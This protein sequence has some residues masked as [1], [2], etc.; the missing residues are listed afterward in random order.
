MTPYHTSLTFATLYGGAIEPRLRVH[1][2]L[3]LII[4]GGDLLHGS[5][6][7]GV[8]GAP[9]AGMHHV[10]E[11]TKKGIDRIKEEVCAVF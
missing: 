8:G 10:A 7:G 3:A 2:A 11:G 6:Q 9:A 4:A 5:A 1:N